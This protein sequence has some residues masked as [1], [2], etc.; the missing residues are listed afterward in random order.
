MARPLINKIV[1]RLVL[2]AIVLGAFEGMSAG[3]YFI[4]FGSTKFAPLTS[5]GESAKTVANPAWIIHPYYG[6]LVSERWM[7]N[8][9]PAGTPIPPINEDGFISENATIQKRS[10]NKLIVGVIGGSFARLIA[11][12]GQSLERALRAVPRFQGREIVIVNL[13][14]SAAKEPQQLMILNDV[15]AR[16]GEFDVILNVDGFNE[17]VLFFAHGNYEASVNLYYPQSWTI[18]SETQQSAR[19]VATIGKIGLAQ[20]LRQQIG[21]AYKRHFLVSHTMTGQLLAR[22][23]DAQLARYAVNLELSLQSDAR[24]IAAARSELRLTRDGRT[25]L[26]PRNNYETIGE[27]YATQARH[28]ALSSEMLNNLTLSQGGRYFHVLHP[29]QYFVGSKT[30]SNDEMATGYDVKSPYRLPAERGYPFLRSAGAALSSAGVNF[31]DL[32]LAFKD[33]PKT[34]YV[35]TCCHVNEAGIEKLARAIADFVDRTF[36]RSQAV[37]VSDAQ[38]RGENFAP[39]RLRGYAIQ[40]PYEDGYAIPVQKKP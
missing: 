2:V 36:E 5:T 28:W 22:G 16:G 12:T 23:T 11:R 13:S 33:D 4:L 30:L 8:N 37:N 27:I 35:D 15:I 34:Y 18:I 21:D 25:F 26:G 24:S 38:F 3:A 1:F 7:Q 20:A 29:N 19:D 6:Y 14:I 39:E 31:L 17:I 9:T 32:S 10:P 40:S